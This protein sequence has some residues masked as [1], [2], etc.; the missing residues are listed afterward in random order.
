MERLGWVDLHSGGN[1]DQVLRRRLKQPSDAAHLEAAHR[2]CDGIATLWRSCKER[3][4]QRKGKATYRAVSTVE[5]DAQSVDGSR[6]QAMSVKD[7]I[8]G[9]IET[10]LEDTF[11]WRYKKP[12][13]M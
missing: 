5:Y 12:I 1:A 11:S 9:L 6:G 4:G 3:S 7:E 10:L 2:D 8:R 13:Q